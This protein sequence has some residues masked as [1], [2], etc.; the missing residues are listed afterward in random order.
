[1]PRIQ[2]AYPKIL[3]SKNYPS[4][5]CIAFDKYD[6]TN[7]H[8]VWEVELG[9]YGFG[10]RRDRFDLDERGIAEF[11]AAHPGLEEA[12]NL[13]QKL[14]ATP[15]DKLF[16]ENPAYNSPEITVFTE[17]FGANSFAGM[18]KPEESKQLILFD[19]E[20]NRGMIPPEQFVQDF[21]NLAI[22]RVV[23]RGKLTGQFV[24]DVRA[25]KYGLAEGVVCKGG[26]NSADLWM[27]KIK[28]N[29]YMKKLQQ[30]FQNDWENYWE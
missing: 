6:G 3:G 12:S 27:I 24:E 29:A 13:F 2:L 4:S 10:T 5:C 15:L 16:R 18:H 19:V 17:F 8:W 30:A 9:W 14:F 21:S 1:M 28:T 26:S 25:G 7:L 20:T 22:A 23:Y 11:N